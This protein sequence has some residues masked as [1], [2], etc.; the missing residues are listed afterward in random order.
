MRPLFSGTRDE[1]A[2]RAARRHTVV[3]G[4][5]RKTDSP[6]GRALLLKHG[7]IVRVEPV[8]GGYRLILVHE[9]RTFVINHKFA[10]FSKTYPIVCAI[11]EKGEVNLVHWTEIR[12][13]TRQP[14]NQA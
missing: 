7:D 14:Q 5:N 6:F 4:Q 10:D 13:R 9:G 8:H 11:I 2:V 1:L 3:R 12:R